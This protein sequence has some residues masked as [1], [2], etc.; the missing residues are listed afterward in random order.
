MNNNN[1]CKPKHNDPTSNPIQLLRRTNSQVAAVTTAAGNALQAD[2]EDQPV[3]HYPFHDE[4]NKNSKNN[5]MSCGPLSMTLDELALQLGGRGRAQLV[6]D[7][8]S[9]GVDPALLHGNSN[10]YNSN[11]NHNSMIADDRDAFDSVAKHLPSSRRTQRL[12]ATAL[13][14]LSHLLARTIIHDNSHAQTIHDAAGF[15]VEGGLTTLSHVS[16][17][18]DGTTKLLL[19]LHDGWQVETVII[20]WNGIRSTLC[21]SSQVGCRQ[22]C[23]FCATG[24]M[25]LKRSLNSDEILAQMFWARKL[26]R[27]F[28]LKE[29]KEENENDH[30]QNTATNNK[31][32]IARNHN[33]NISNNNDP[34]SKK[35]NWLSS[36]SLS[37]L[38]PITNV[39]FMGMGEPADNL[40]AVIKAVEILTTRELF[41]LSARKVTVSTVAP[42][43]QA[44]VDFATAPCVLAWSVHAARDELRQTL[45]PTTAYSMKELQQGFIQALL[46]KPY[47]FRTA[48]LEVVLIDQ[49]NDSI[50]K[51]ATALVKLSRAIIDAVPGCKLAVNLIPYNEIYQQPEQQQLVA[52]TAAAAAAATVFPTPSRLY[53][54]PSQA[55]VLAFQKYL[56]DHEVYTHVRTTR[57]DDESAACGQLATRAATATQKKVLGPMNA[58]HHDAQ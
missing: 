29:D 31:N 16:Q 50:E 14:Q 23:R 43:P 4:H 40:A 30:H 41:Q 26:C 1:H 42:T 58:I 35:Q 20:P 8:Y 39:V 19:Q 44:F 11:H 32:Q 45:V 51:D 46:L 48:M 55:S 56:W 25:G 47:N 2:Q 22:A 3:D 37:P 24:K 7:C 5:N 6:W 53:R 17:A 36:L 57:G 38:P 13:A 54:A 52:A 49:V 12:G 18:R 21:I 10:H 28:P 34:S 27:W 15:C 33:N 9:I